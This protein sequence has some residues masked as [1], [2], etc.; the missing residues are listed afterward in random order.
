M[1]EMEEGSYYGVVIDPH[2]PR[3]DR[4]V[5]AFF[6]GWY[7]TRAGADGAAEYF[8]AKSPGAN[9]CVVMMLVSQKSRRDA[10]MD[11]SHNPL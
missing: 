3:E 8:A 7:D 4:G 6:D 11:F 2:L 9:V 5:P 10:R 1:T